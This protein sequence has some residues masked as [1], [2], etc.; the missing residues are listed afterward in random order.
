MNTNVYDEEAP[1]GGEIEV[2]P[3][4]LVKLNSELKFDN[5]ARFDNLKKT[6]KELK[7]EKDFKWCE[8]MINFLKKEN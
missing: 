8:K 4:D 7:W 3:V 1:D 6:Y 2:C 5:Y